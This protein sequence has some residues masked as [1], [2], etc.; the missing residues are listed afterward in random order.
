MPEKK[1]DQYPMV[2]VV[3]V[4]SESAGDEWELSEACLEW[5]K[6]PLT[7]GDSVGRLIYKGKD[8]IVLYSHLLG[9]SN[10]LHG[11]KIPR[12]FIR[13]IKYLDER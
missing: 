9:K 13:E 12:R 5:A 6:K 7:G 11:L 2:R 1:K 3:W 4:D 8:Y 10:W